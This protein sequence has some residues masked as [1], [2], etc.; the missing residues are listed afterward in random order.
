MA[1]PRGSHLDMTTPRVAPVT[2]G[3]PQ[4]WMTDTPM[5][6]VTEAWFAPGDVLDSHTHDRSI[7]AVMIDGSFET[8][9][10]T[11]RIECA[12]MTW[13]TEPVEEAHENVI[14]SAGAHAVVVQPD[15]SYHELLQPFAS[16]LFEVRHGKNPC[17]AL[18]ARKLVPE[19]RSTDSLSP[20]VIESELLQLMTNAARTRICRER[21]MPPW[22]S[23]AR[24]LLHEGFRQ[25][26]DLVAIANAV[27]ITPWHLARAFRQFF[28]CT[29]GEYARAIRLHW[30][31]GR[32]AQTND[33]IARIA[34]EAGYADQS[35]FTRDCSSAVGR[36][37]SVYR[38]LARETRRS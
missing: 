21:R 18:G 3:S 31:L 34:I 16:L 32:I 27:D 12:P 5:F 25:R 2:L 23:Q 33:S 26:L 19:V 22:L 30:S 9:I 13:W 8:A 10:G 28:A 14:G 36:S 17:I 37:P 7:I 6:R 20:L 11:R 15:P 1:L 24:E 35:H 4:F 38:R 29:A